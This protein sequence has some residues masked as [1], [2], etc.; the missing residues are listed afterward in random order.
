MKQ[1]GNIITKNI[2]YMFAFTLAE[3]LITLGIIGIVAAITIP[4]LIQNS[5]E[6]ATVSQL[7]KTYSTLSQAVALAVQEYGTIDT[8]D[9]GNYGDTGK[10]INIFNKLS[11]YLK[12]SKT[13]TGPVSN[14]C[15]P[16]NSYNLSGG[17]YAWNWDTVQYRA[18]LVDG[19]YLYVI[20]GTANCISNFGTTANLKQGCAYIYA[21]INGSKSPNTIGK[22]IFLFYLLKNQLFPT[23][24][25]NDTNYVFSSDCAKE[26]ASWGNSCTAWVLYNENM[27]YLECTGLNWGVKIACS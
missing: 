15:N 18:E 17:S 11:P 21:D 27:D 10:A 13:C 3:V 8:W 19:T 22:D 1:I 12:I 23:G 9:L 5:Q 2:E 7:K 14:G 6:K 26:S 4:S 16:K 24:T 20:N 25:A